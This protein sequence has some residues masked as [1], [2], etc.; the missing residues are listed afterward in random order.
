MVRR[1]PAAPPPAPDTRARAL[2][3]WVGCAANPNTH[4]PGAPPYRTKPVCV[5]TM[6]SCGQRSDRCGRR[7]GSHCRW[8]GRMVPPIIE[9]HTPAHHGRCV[10]AKSRPG[11]LAR[12]VLFARAWLSGGSVR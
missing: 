10:S 11:S 4:P 9:R 2:S 6:V 8:S 5:S 12:N 7:P 1:S 3:L